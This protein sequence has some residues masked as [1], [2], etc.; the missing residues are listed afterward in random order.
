MRKRWI[1]AVQFGACI[2]AWESPL[3]AF[4]GVFLEFRFF[5][6]LLANVILRTSPMN[7]LTCAK[8]PKS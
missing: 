8:H 4:A 2:I 7:D 3:S 5:C 1:A 6:S